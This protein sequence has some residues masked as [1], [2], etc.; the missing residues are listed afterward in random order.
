MRRNGMHAIAIIARHVVRDAVRSR[1][2]HGAVLLALGV[3]VAAPIAGRLTAGQDVKVVKDLS[4]A[5]INLAGLFITVSMGVQV[6][7]R[8]IE[9]RTVDAV[10]S[11]PI[12]RCEFILGQYGGLM[13]TLAIGLSAMAVAMYCV[14]AATVWWLGDAGSA[15]APAADPALL[16]AVFLIFVQLAVVAAAAFCFATFASPA[17]AA[18]ATCGLYVIG[19][20]G[21]E[22]RNLDGVVDAPLAAAFAAGLSYV[23]PDLAA[24][25][26]KAAVVHAQPVTAAYMALTAG[27]GAAYSAA[28]LVLAV[29]VFERRDLT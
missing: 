7:A 9:R 24:F 1:R 20:F 13:A 8:E 27:S 19:Q 14:L 10:L 5:A 4:L 15:P 26:V 18:A 6:V 17:L 23:L 16:K 3:A 21:T 25:D 11:K 28:F 22:L 2:L 12:R 29:A